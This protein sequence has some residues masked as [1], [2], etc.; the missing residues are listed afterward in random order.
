M[1]AQRCSDKRIGRRSDIRYAAL[2]A[3]AESLQFIAAR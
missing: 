3:A 1:K 2:D